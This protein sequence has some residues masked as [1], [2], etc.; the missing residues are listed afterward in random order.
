MRTS[1]NRPARHRPIKW[2]HEGWLEVCRRQELERRSL[3]RR[4]APFGVYRV[5]TRLS[6]T[7]RLRPTDVLR[8]PDHRDLSPDAFSIVSVIQ[9]M[10]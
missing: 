4:D 8:F 6:L 2:P 10:W 3:S 5:S 1:R 9:T 7:L